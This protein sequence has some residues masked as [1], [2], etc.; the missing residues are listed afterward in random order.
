M[1]CAEGEVGD[2]EGFGRVW[3]G[4]TA[5]DGSA[6]MDHFVEGEEGCRGETEG[7]L[8]EGVAD[9]ADVD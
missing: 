1:I 6:V 8:G 5:G 3:M 4:E 2:E 7:D 9:E